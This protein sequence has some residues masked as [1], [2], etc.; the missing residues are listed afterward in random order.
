ML[1][2]ARSPSAPFSIDTLFIVG[3]VAGLPPAEYEPTGERAEPDKVRVLQLLEVFI[4]TGYGAEFLRIGELD[5]ADEELLRAKE[6]ALSFRGRIDAPIDHHLGNLRRRQWRLDEARASYSNALDNLKV[7][8]PIGI[9]T[10]KRLKVEVFGDLAELEMLEGRIDDALAWSDRALDLVRAE[11]SPETEAFVLNRRAEIL[12]RGGR[13]AAA[14][15]VFADALALAEEKGAFDHQVSIHLSRANMNMRRGRH[16]A[17]AA[18]LEKSL[19]VLA[20]S[21]ELFREPAILGNLAMNYILLD[22]DDTARLLLQKAR[23]VAEESGR[24]R[25]AFRRP[26]S[27]AVPR[28]PLFGLGA[29]LCT[30][31]RRYPVSGRDPVSFFDR[32][33]CA[34]IFTASVRR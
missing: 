24:S 30:G 18:H 10:P 9:F 4:R 6:A 34:S 19:E 20:G 22:A 31:S 27:I 13:F 33:M 2:N 5:N 29:D 15:K 14:E 3:P 1:E 25:A 12:V 8:R 26:R 23:Q 21:D 11:N 17:A 16:G 32:R 28:R 7:L